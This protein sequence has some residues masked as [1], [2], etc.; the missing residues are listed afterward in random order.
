ML[1]K[2]LQSS[3]NSSDNNAKEYYASKAKT[4]YVKLNLSAP[5]SVAP[6]YLIMHKEH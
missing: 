4:G 6:D 2:P 3:L 5:N 1:D